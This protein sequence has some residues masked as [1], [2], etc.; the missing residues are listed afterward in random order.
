MRPILAL[1][2]LALTPVHALAYPIL[3][4]TRRETVSVDP[5]RYRLTFE[6]RLVNPDSG[7]Y[8]G[9]YMRVTDQ[10][11]LYDCTAP[12][13]WQC[14]SA[15]GST[16]GI[17]WANHSQWSGPLTFSFVTD[18]P[19]PCVTILF[20]NPILAKHPAT[21]DNYYLQV[22]LDPDAPMPALATSWGR[23]RSIYR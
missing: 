4:V 11:H 2:L 18:Q 5:P 12:S 1:A 19:V 16:P 20:D 17:Y 3:D 6:V 10:S 14:A 13:L 21:N 23:I 8:Y 7:D 22:C 15:P 9:L